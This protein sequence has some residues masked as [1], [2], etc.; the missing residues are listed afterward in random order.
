MCHQDGQVALMLAAGED[1]LEP[2]QALIKAGADLE[3]KDNEVSLGLATPIG[4]GRWYL[5]QV[6]GVSVRF[7]G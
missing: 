5:L 6:L 4:H 7:M 2:V 3:A 1:H